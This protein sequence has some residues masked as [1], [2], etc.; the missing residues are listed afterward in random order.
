MSQAYLRKIDIMLYL[1]HSYI[2]LI[3]KTMNTCIYLYGMKA[4]AK[5]PRESRGSAG[6]RKRTMVSGKYGRERTSQK[7]Y[8]SVKGSLVIS[9]KMNTYNKL[10]KP[11]TEK[12]LSLKGQSLC[13]CLEF[14]SGAMLPQL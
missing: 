6:K 11:M 1:M 5:L 3:H 4:E 14:W 8:T 7:M 2:L 13:G 12:D 10:L 9:C